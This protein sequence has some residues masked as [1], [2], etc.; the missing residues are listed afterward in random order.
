MFLLL[1]RETNRRA[2]PGWAG[3]SGTRMVMEGIGLDGLGMAW[4]GMAENGMVR[5]GK[6]ICL[7][8]GG[9]IDNRRGWVVPGLERLGIEWRRIAGLGMDRYGTA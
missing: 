7:E 1:G 6:A 3:Q 5:R 2:W 9:L 4:R 8:S